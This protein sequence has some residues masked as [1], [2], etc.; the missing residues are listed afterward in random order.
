MYNFYVYAYVR[1]TNGTPYYIGKGTGLRAFNPHKGI[2][3]PKDRTKIIFL[4]DNLSEVGALALERRL[5]RWWGRKDNNTGVLLN[6]T[7]GGD[8]LSGYKHTEETKKR[9]KESQLG[10]TRTPL[11]QDHKNKLKGKR[12]PYGTMSMVERK[13]RS[14]TMTGVRKS[15]QHKKNTSN[16]RR[17]LANRLIVTQIK[18]LKMTGLPKNWVFMSEEKL[19][20]FIERQK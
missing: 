16:A 17:E 13:K 8:G 15:E 19:K 18:L 3:V 4:E 6:R 1:K 2:G 12:K 14:K 9:I 7:D 5:I 11:S 20:N 10:V